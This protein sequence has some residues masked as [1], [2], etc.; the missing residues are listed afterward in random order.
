MTIFMRPMFAGAV[1]FSALLTG[2]IHAETYPARPVQLL[3]GYGA[4]GV[5]DVCVRALAK[6]VSAQ[7]GQPIAVENKPGAGSSLAINH[8]TRQKPDGYQLG[9][10]ATGAVLNQYLVKDV[11]YDV[12]TDVTPIAM[13][14]QIPFG[15]LVRKDSPYQSIND[16]ITKA[17]AE[18]ESV[19]YS[20]AGVGSPQHLVA[21]ELGKILDIQW[22]HVPYKS[23]REASLAMLR[24]DVDF[25]SDVVLPDARDER[26]RFLSAYTKDRMEE[27]QNVPTLLDEGHQLVAPS[28][29]G[30]AGPKGMDPAVVKRVSAAIETSINTPAYEQCAEQFGLQKTYKNPDDFRAYIQEVSDEWESVATQLAEQ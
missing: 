22:T 30:I 27:F 25:M 24:G 11:G 4:G 23:G 13:F 3:V 21:A 28:I 12:A 16:I 29:L 8:L 19:T 6:G 7:L 1:L 26:F 18:P 10:L 5:T 14:A 15:I 17:K 20:T 2:N 9:V